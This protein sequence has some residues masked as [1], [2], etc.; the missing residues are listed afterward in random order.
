MAEYGFQAV[1]DYGSVTI[2]STYKLM[3]FSER[4]LVTITSSYID[5]GGQG[6]ASFAKPILTQEAPQIFVRVQ[7]ASHGSLGLYCTILGAPGNWTGVRIDTAATGSSPLQNFVLEFVVCKFT[8]AVQNSGYGMNIWD[9]NGFPVFSAS[10]K[11][12]RYSKFAINWTMVTDASTVR[13]FAPD[14]SID[15]DDFICVSAMDRGVNW[16]TDNAQFAAFNVWA[17]WAPNL[18]LYC[19]RVTAGGY[20]YWQ[21]MNNTQFAVPVCKFPSDRY[22]N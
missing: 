11:V 17:N 5:R 3:V 10:D 19:Q 8:D 20:W 7:S 21:G 12:V 16:F 15:A 6:Q 9:E 18:Y 2:S 1:N 4:G 22:A 14:V 13:T